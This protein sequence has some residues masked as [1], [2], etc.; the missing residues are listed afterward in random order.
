M[1]IYL[2]KISMLWCVHSMLKF[3]TTQLLE[4]SKNMIAL[5]ISAG[6]WMA[7]SGDGFYLKNMHPIIYQEIKSRWLI[8]V[9]HH[10]IAI[11]NIIFLKR[12]KFTKS[13][14]IAGV[15][16]RARGSFS[17][18]SNKNFRFCSTIIMQIEHIVRTF[19]MFFDFFVNKKEI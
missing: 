11:F 12:R 8:N 15:T 10:D 13:C 9:R 2:C 17:N 7:I 6:Y 16:T 19:Q 18:E 3:F 14:W 1:G 4:I 5:S